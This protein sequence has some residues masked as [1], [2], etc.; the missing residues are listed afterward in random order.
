MEVNSRKFLTVSS[1]G[2]R[3]RFRYDDD[4]T[5]KPSVIRKSG[6]L[7]EVIAEESLSHSDV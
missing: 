2:A 3:G 6:R 7:W 1:K 4:L 5:G